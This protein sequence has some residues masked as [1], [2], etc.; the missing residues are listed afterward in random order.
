VAAPPLPEAFGNYAIKGIA[1]VLP[2]EPVSWLPATAGWKVLALLALS[3]AG[4]LAY[5][6]LKRWRRNRYR[7]EALRELAGLQQLSPA[8]RLE[9][10][11]VVLKATA[12]R[13]WPRHEVAALS[14]A[15]WT[16]WLAG[17]GAELSDP[18][19]ELLAGGQYRSAA[20]VDEA[21]VERL[22][23]EVAGWIRSHRDPLP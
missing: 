12:L 2:P 10:I 1:E 18:S 16:G 22:Q 6:R 9:A 11:A 15:S 20:A 13:A 23:A 14:G 21:A 7:R 4:W 19:R 8:Q 17:A 3:F 5:R